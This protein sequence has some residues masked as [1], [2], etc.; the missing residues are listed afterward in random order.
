MNF[1]ALLTVYVIGWLI[2]YSYPRLRALALGAVRSGVVTDGDAALACVR[3][4]RGWRPAGGLSPVPA[5]QLVNALRNTFCTITSESKEDVDPDLEL[6][7]H[8][9]CIHNWLASSGR[10][11]GLR[12][13]E[14]RNVGDFP[15]L[16]FEIDL[17]YEHAILT[18]LHVAVDGRRARHQILAWT[19]RSRFDRRRLDE[20][21][22]GFSEAPGPE[23]SRIPSPASFVEPSS[24]Y[25]AH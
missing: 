19:S 24:R 15:A 10:I 17:L 25:K 23:P 14:L 3:V 22:A 7:A 1:P 2:L 11:I 5:I 8:A 6:A 9:G 18:Y 20:V 13:P 21:L 16:V 12:G 4:P